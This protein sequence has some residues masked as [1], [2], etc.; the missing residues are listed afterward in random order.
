MNTMTDAM[1]MTQ[2]AR[3][4]NAL[5]AT[6]AAHR[7]GVCWGAVF[8][9]ALG[10][11]SLSLILLVLGVGLGLSS[12]SPWASE[13]ISAETF[14]VSTILWLSF[15]Q[16]AAS[17]VGGYMA[18]RLRSRWA[19]LHGDEVYF[20]DTAHGFLAWSLA[21]LVTAGLLGSA[22]GTVISGGAKAGAVVA[23]AAGT[24]AAAPAAAMA[25]NASRTGSSASSGYFVDSLFRKD[26]S[27]AAT[28]GT[29]PAPVGAALATAPLGSN[30]D[31]GSAPS[32]EAGR[33]FANGIRN[34][35]L[36]PEDVTY[37]AQVVAQRTQISQADAEKRVR[38]TFNRMQTAANTAKQDAQ[39]A[40]DKARKASAMASL[41]CFVAL[42]I[43]AFVAS[44]TA[45]LGGRHR[46]LV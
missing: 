28:A 22:V 8:A 23:G 31:D 12:V 24:A 17:G 4:A 21:T 20:R 38:D 25:A 7:H 45:T 5:E 16:L 43:G 34:G 13:G 44:L 32:G 40:A 15:T 6:P 1:E 33:I 27:A 37:L 14:G 46:D 30:T 19:S 9:G 36:P 11:A 3:A 10:A 39:A 35:S 2:R 26:T 42:L 41:W 29:T 18:G